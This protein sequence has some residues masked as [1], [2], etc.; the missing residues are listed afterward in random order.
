MHPTAGQG[1][2]GLPGRVLGGIEKGH[3]AD[4]GQGPLIGNP[5]GGLLGRYLLVGHGD[6]PQAVIIEIVVELVQLVAQLGI[7]GHG[8]AVDAHLV[9]D[10][11]DLLNGPFADQFMVVARF[12]DHD[13][14]APAH[15]IKGDLV[16]FAITL[17][18][19]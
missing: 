12:V 16:Y 6:H 9:A 13:R 18:H 3:Q 4:Q 2:K 8:L 5:I 11:G 19:I 17:V 10:L 14:H 7:E 1:G 15:E